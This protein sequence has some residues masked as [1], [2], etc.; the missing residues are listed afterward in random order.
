MKRSEVRSLLF[1]AVSSKLVG[2]GFKPRPAGYILVRAQPWGQQRLDL[3]IADYNPIFELAPV[4]GI[5]WDAAEDV[6]HLFSGAAPRDH[7][8][9]STVTTT[10]SY[11][12]LPDEWEGD[13]EASIRAAVDEIARFAADLVVP[14]F[15]RHDTLE[16][17]DRALNVERPAGFDITN[18]SDHA[19]HALIV[20]RLA[21]NPEFESLVHEYDMA[22]LGYVEFE[23]RKFEDLVAYLRS[24][25]A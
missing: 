3:T 4:L 21:H 17:L 15:D 24:I 16:A 23:R 20:A 9:S 5:R 18:P 13:D 6:Y 12:G 25:P 14:F 2:H 8:L 11:F 10:G 19:R 7:G 1:G 22:L